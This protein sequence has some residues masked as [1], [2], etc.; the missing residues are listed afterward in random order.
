MWDTV[1]EAN[2][3]QIVN[4]RTAEMVAQA[5]RYSG[6]VAKHPTGARAA[7]LVSMVDSAE[8]RFGTFQ[9]ERIMDSPNTPQREFQGWNVLQDTGV[10]DGLPTEREHCG[11]SGTPRQ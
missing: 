2:L 4:A 6:Y 5:Q 8:L 9:Q 1:K 3:A 10:G 11:K 7:S